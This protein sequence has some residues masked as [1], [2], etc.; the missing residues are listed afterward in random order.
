MIVVVV[1]TVTVVHAVVAGSDAIASRAVAIVVVTVAAIVRASGTIVA[2]HD[3]AS[4]A[5]EVNSALRRRRPLTLARSNR[6][7]GQL[8][9]RQA[10][11]ARIR[12]RL[13]DNPRVCV[14]DDSRP[15]L[16]LAGTPTGARI[17]P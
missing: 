6:H 5:I 4:T 10:G 17:V 2:M 11:L 12:V 16:M 1:A 15:R 7:W 3:R 8:A 13:P 14:A 9:G